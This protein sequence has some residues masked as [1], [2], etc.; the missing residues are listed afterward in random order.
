MK[1]IRVTLGPVLHDV[2]LHPLRTPGADDAAESHRL[3]GLEIVQHRQRP[4]RE[5]VL[6]DQLDGDVGDVAHL[7][8][9]RHGD[10]VRLRPGTISRVEDHVAG[11]GGLDCAREPLPLVGAEEHPDLDVGANLEDGS[12]L[13]PERLVLLAEELQGNV[14][15]QAG[16]PVADVEHVLQRPVARHE[17]VGPGACQG[18]VGDLDLH[19]LAHLEAAAWDLPHQL[20]GHVG[21]DAHAGD[22]EVVCELHIAPG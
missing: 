17:P 3:V 15:S 6:H 1:V 14:G 7:G 12:V 2:G 16:I 13:G 8:I 22:R 11:A 19:E 9:V 18:P 4:P 21:G 10:G 5:L 20:D